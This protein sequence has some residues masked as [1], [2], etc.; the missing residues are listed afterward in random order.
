M[1]CK[2]ASLPKPPT[3][4][5]LQNSYLR[6]TESYLNLPCHQAFRESSAIEIWKQSPK[7]QSV[8]NDDY[9]VFYLKIRL[10]NSKECET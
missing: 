6:T 10:W 4:E 5:Y 2:G 8:F 3:K 7:T 9:N 1:L